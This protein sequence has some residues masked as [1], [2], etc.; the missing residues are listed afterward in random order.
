M[1]EYLFVYGTL[2]SQ[3][4]PP[5]L[6]GLVGQLRRFGAAAYTRGHLYDLGT[7]P[8][9]VLDSDCDRRIIGEVLELPGD[10]SVLA[11]LDRYE[12]ID[13]NQPDAG[14]FVRTECHVILDNGQA[15]ECWIYVYN[16]EISSEKLI[17][18][19][20]YLGNRSHS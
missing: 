7:Y 2:R 13:G 6:S 5:D 14:L 9:A 11:A 1:A 15:I 20:D 10:K 16:G 8:G 4:V 19:G 18:S 17:E 12:G 3:L